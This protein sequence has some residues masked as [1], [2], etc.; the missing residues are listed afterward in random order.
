MKAK[1]IFSWILRLTVAVILLQTLYF[2]F[3][4]HAD[5]VHIFSELGVE[6]WGR[7]GLGVIELITV[8]LIL[9]PKTKIFGMITSL[10]IML[11]AVFSHIMVLG[12]VVENDSGG[13]F[14]LAMI[15]L[16][17]SALHIILNKN[18]LNIPNKK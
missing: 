10:G 8:L 4:G 18:D 11:G 3:T 6:P 5:S 7:I 1:K 16:F 2:K 17:A 9:L 15:V 14:T 12:V 13:L